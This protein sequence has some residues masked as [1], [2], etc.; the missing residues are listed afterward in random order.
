[1]SWSGVVMDPAIVSSTFQWYIETILYKVFNWVI[2]FLY[3]IVKVFVDFFTQAPVLG[4][5]VTIAIVYGAWRML[6]RKWTSL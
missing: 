5:L 4:A 1:M 2:S 6:K 3:G